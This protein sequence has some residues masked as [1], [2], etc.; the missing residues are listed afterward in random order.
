MISFI[1]PAFNEA[2][3]IKRFT[4]EVMPVFDQLGESY[5]III[6]DDG[7]RDETAA[8]ARGLNHPAVR[9]VQH[10][11]NRGLGAAIRTGIKE[12]KG[13]IVITMDSDLTFSPTLVAPMLERFRRGDVDVVS[14]SP[15]LAGF[16]KDIPSYRVFVSH[17][18][19]LIYR[20]VMGA[21]VTTVSPI[22]RL[23]K[24]EQ[25]LSLPLQSTGFDINA[26]ILFYLIR[27]GAR[28]A[29]IPAPLT[30]RLHGESKLN[31]RKEMI[32]HLRLL[33]RMLAL[34]F[35]KPKRE[36]V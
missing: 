24:R 2:E 15:K 22:F 12:A 19:T 9:L 7:S 33:R 23:Y 11:R 17:A 26:E 8:V 16:G 5:E 32:R 6:V 36:T 4:T 14:G 35:Q 27:N 10:D 34:R 25:L 13:D 28:I 3:N 29:E 18:A 31:Y 30:Q 1:F 21:R 20:L